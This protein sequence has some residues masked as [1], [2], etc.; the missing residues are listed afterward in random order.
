MPAEQTYPQVYQSR[1]GRSELVLELDRPG[2]ALP[3]PLAACVTL[4]NLIKLPGFRFLMKKGDRAYVT[5]SL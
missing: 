4:G 5:E 1:N 2:Q 3:L